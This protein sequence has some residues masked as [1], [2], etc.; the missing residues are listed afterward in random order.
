MNGRTVLSSTV[1]FLIL[2]G[3]LLSGC[4]SQ[5]VV[6]NAQIEISYQ[7]GHNSHRYILHESNQAA[8]IKAF[9]DHYLM[10]EIDI[11]TDNFSKIAGDTTTILAYF[12]KNPASKELSP[13]RT[14]FL[15]S[16]TDQ[17]KNQSVEGCRGTEEGAA[18]GKLIKDVE[19]LMA[20]PAATHG[21][22]RKN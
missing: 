11:S 3:A 7:R 1:Y 13:C 14:P 2:A 17:S 9:K 18:L 10:K 12:K 5:P 20:S 21:D 19:F 6:E 4:A 22:V 15:L 8:T 16:F